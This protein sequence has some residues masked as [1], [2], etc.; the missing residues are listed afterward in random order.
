MDLCGPVST[1]SLGGKRYILVI[2]D[3]YTRYTWVFFFKYKSDTTEE[4][5]NFIKKSEVFNGQLVRSIR[6]DNGTEFRNATVDTFLND[7]GSSQNFAAVRTPQQNGVVERKNRTLC[8]VARFML[9]ESNLP[10]YFWVEAVNT[11]CFTQNRS[12]IVKRHNKTSYEVFYGRKSN[13]SFLHVFGCLCFILNDQEH[14]GKFD[15]K[16]DEGILMGYSLSSKAYRV[17]NLRRKC[18]DESIHVKFDDHKTSSLSCDDNELHEW[19][20]SCVGEDSPNLLSAGPPYVP[21]SATSTSINP[22]SADFLPTTEHVASAEPTFHSTPLHHTHPIPTDPSPLYSPSLYPAPLPPALKCTKDHP[23]EQIIGDQQTGVQT[24]RGVENIC[25]YVNFLSIM[26]PKKIEEALIDPCWITAMQEKLFNSKET[27]NK[28]RLVA[29]GYRQKEGIDYDETFAPVARLEAIRIFLA[30]A[31]HK[32]FRVFQMD[33]K[34]AFINGELTEEVYVKQPPGFEDPAHPHYVFRLDKAL[35]GLKQAPRACDE[36]LCQE[37]ASLIKSKYE[38][39][40]MGE[41]TFFLGLQIKQT[42]EGIFI[43]LSKYIRDLL[44]KFDFENCSPM[45]TPMALPLKIHADPAGKPVDITNY[46]GMIGSLLYL[47]ASRPDIMYATCL[48][49]RYQANPKES[50]LAVVKRI[51]RYLKVKVQ[52]KVVNYSVEIWSAGPSRNNILSL[53]LLL[54]LNMLQLEV[55]VHRSCG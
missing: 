51:F 23:I 1:P 4:I 36:S 33:V 37:F 22:N 19:I 5:I 13:I 2:I 34:S 3:E 9:S 49:V 8:K 54:K 48:C 7:K 18:I 14:L 10:T 45:K 17:Y 12:I 6:S 26:E 52:L 43:N 20:T 39:S 30:H 28:A 53:P 29:Q 21:F 15:P 24:R 44:K 55:I 41:L 32:N 25:L 38:M 42:S 16:A 11:A 47:T 27:K 50:H 35:Y 46:R 31:A 40:M